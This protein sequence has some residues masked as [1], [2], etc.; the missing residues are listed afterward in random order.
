MNF[1]CWLAWIIR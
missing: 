1:K